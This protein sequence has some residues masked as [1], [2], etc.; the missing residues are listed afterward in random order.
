MKN[1]LIGFAIVAGLA[2]SIVSQILSVLI[3]AAISGFKIGSLRKTIEVEV[4]ELELEEFRTRFN[5]RLLEL[6]FRGSSNDGE[7]IQHGEV[8]DLSSFTHARTKKLLKVEFNPC[9]KGICRVVLTLK[10]LDPIVADTGESAYRDAVLNYLAGYADEMVV[11]P[12]LCH[13]GV[14]GF[15]GGI[16]AL[17][18]LAANFLFFQTLFIDASV[19]FLCLNSAVLAIL[20]IISTVRMPK[21]IKGLYLSLCGLATNIF[22][23]AAVAIQHSSVLLDKLK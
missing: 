8:N 14:C 13:N 16:I 9:C 15:N 23:I 17:T 3:S 10:Y 19:F 2:L 22:C 4:R 11:V 6:G 1:H 20:G 5:E 12:N 21:E 7:F 18:L